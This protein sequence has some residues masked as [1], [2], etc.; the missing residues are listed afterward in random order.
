[1]RM[2]GEE[3]AVVGAGPAGLLTALFINNYDIKVFEEHRHVGIPKHCA[4]FVGLET[5]KILTALSSKEI[6]DRAFDSVVFHTP[7]GSF[8]IDFPKP[9]IFRV[10]RPL[11]EE[12]LLDRV[13][14]KGVEVNFGSKVKPANKPGSIVIDGYEYSFEWI[15]ASDGL[16]SYFRRKYLGFKTRFLYGLNALFRQKGSVDEVHIIY[17]DL[18]PCFFTWY[19]TTSDGY[20]FLGYGSHG[21]VD[22]F[23]ISRLVEKKVG[24]KLLERIEIYGGLIP[25]GVMLRKP[26]LNN[27]LFIGDSAYMIKPYTGGG[28]GII[29]RLAPIMGMS[30]DKGNFTEYLGV[31]ERI[32]KRLLLEYLVTLPLRNRGYW[33]PA[34]ILYFVEN[35][36]GVDLDLVEVFDNHALLLIRTIPYLTL[37]LIHLVLS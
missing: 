16:C 4:G 12:K 13:L 10:N 33:I 11:L 8:K 15:I 21:Y 9:F 3:V 36:L 29:S 18:T 24:V 6:L 5:Y 14:S 25:F 1:M 27:V 2:F 17:S 37:A 31:Y 34:Y 32:R 23:K 19:A 26:V 35:V 20:G 30:I 7:R 28:L 22:L